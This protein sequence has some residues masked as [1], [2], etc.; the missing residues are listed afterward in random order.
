MEILSYILFALALNV[1]SF[2]TSLTYGAKSIKVPPLSI[3]IISLISM[4][5]IAISM[6]AGQLLAAHIPA[7]LAY[8]LGSVL[9]L[10]IGLWILFQITRGKQAKNYRPCENPLAKTFEIRL[11]PFGLVIQILKEPSR[12]DFDSSGVITPRE[13]LVLGIALAVDAFAAGYAVSLLGFSVLVTAPAVGLGHFFLACLGITAG[14]SITTGLVG[15]QLNV[16]PG[17]ILIL[18]GL[19]KIR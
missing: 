5:S 3:L 18:L 11:R 16:L 14:R 10:L 7:S 19:L 1:D 6:A 17:C 13:A 15:R 4:V 2:C 9:L 8:R 12:A